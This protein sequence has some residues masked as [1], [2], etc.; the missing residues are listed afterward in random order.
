MSSPLLCCDESKTSVMPTRLKT[1]TY[2]KVYTF[3]EIDTLITYLL[4]LDRRRFI[5]LV[6]R[7]A[8]VSNLCYSEPVLHAPRYRRIITMTCRGTR[9]HL[10]AKSDRDCSLQSSIRIFCIYWVSSPYQ[11]WLCD[12]ND[13]HGE[14]FKTWHFAR[15][16][17]ELQRWKP[18]VELD[19][20]WQR[21]GLNNL[22]L[23]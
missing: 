14:A 17:V 19:I 6:T 2:I 7:P 13:R 10:T 18:R 12:E 9:S 3:C 21:V 20:L 4:L 5:K 23:P 15:D 1:D 22:T 8:R 16:E 11:I